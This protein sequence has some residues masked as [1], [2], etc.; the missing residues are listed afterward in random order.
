MHN[1]YVGKV[2]D[3]VNPYIEITAARSGQPVRGHEWVEQWITSHPGRWAL[4]GENGVGLTRRNVESMGWDAGQKTVRGD[5]KIYARIPHPE[6][7]DLLTAL[8]R[9][10]EPVPTP[11][12]AKSEFN[13][14]PH[15]LAEATRVARENLF[16]VRP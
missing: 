10:A 7:E 13:W 8:R 2:A 1:P 5:M 14:T 3:L 16:P 9:S 12:F 4:V 6:A 15:E 11:V